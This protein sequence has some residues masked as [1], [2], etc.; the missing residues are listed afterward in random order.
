MKLNVLLAITDNLRTK[1]KNMIT[2]YA[3]FFNKKGG[4]FLGEKMT[5]TPK[6]GVVDDPSK[7]SYTKVVTTVDEKFSY[8]VAEASDFIDALFSQ[9]RTN[10]MGIAT[11]E[12][13]VDGEPWGIFTSLELLR[14]KSLLEAN[15]LGNIEQVLSNIPVKS[16]AL[17]WDKSSEEEYADR[18]IYESPMLKGVAKTTVKEEYILQDPNLIA[19]RTYAPQ[20][21]M[22]NITMELGDYTTQKFTG[23]WSQRQ[24]AGTLKRRG[25]LIV[26]VVQALKECNDCVSVKSELTADKI[27]GY[28]LDI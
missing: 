22:R 12:L 4:S 28:I 18:S 11:A 3:N 1:Y 14:L 7:R 19:G 9:E 8:F 15:D 23:E 13:V 10:A 25:D 24:K 16:D 27:F 26:A 5:Y 21:S 20:K 17:I 6:E 2:N